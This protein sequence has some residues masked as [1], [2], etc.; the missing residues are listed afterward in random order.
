MRLLNTTTLELSN[1]ISDIPPY[2]ILSHMWGDGEVT[3]QDAAVLPRM[4]RLTSLEALPAA[5]AKLWPG[6]R[7]II[8]FCET[9]SDDGY[10]WAWVDTCCIDKTSSAELSEAINSMYRWYAEAAVCHIYLAD[11]GID[12]QFKSTLSSEE[13]EKSRWFTRGWTLQELIAPVYVEFYDMDWRALGTK[14]HLCPRL[15]ARTSIPESLLLDPSTL[16]DYF[17]ARRFSWASDRVTTRPED[18]AYCLMGIFDVNMPLLYGEGGDKAFTHLQEDFLRQSRDLSLLLW[19]SSYVPSNSSVLSRHPRDFSKSFPLTEWRRQSTQEKRL[20]LASKATTLEPPLGTSSRRGD[21]ADLVMDKMPEPFIVTNGGLR[22]QMLVRL[23]SMDMRPHV[24]LC[25]EFSLRERGSMSESSESAKS[26]LLSSWNN[27]TTVSR[28]RFD[29]VEV[30]NSLEG[31]QL[32]DIYLRTILRRSHPP[33]R[34]WP[35]TFLDLKDNLGESLRVR[36]EY[37][38]SVAIDVLVIPS[39]LG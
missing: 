34:Y 32:K 13:L 35:Q 7:K 11:V 12:Q 8:G 3:F 22:L 24:L 29:S 4:K 17:A 10:G 9:A 20:V 18:V 39:S 15:A 5:N 26:C 31:F 19:T 14:R 38:K 2:A 28:A 36:L 16:P 21:W 30:I 25:T 27:S 6:A 23:I 37:P 1:F 33:R